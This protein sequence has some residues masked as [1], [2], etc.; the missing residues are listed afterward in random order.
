MRK[1]PVFLSLVFFYISAHAQGPIQLIKYDSKACVKSEKVIKEK[2]AKCKNIDSAEHILKRE[3]GF[4]PGNMYVLFCRDCMTKDMI[5]K[6]SIGKLFP[7]IDKDNMHGLNSKGDNKINSLLQL[8][9]TVADSLSVFDSLQLD[10]FNMPPA[11]KNRA[12]T[13]F[14]KIQG[15]GQKYFPKY[16]KKNGLIIVKKE[17]FGDTISYQY[18]LNAFYLDNGEEKLIPGTFYLFFLNSSEKEEL[19]L[20]ARE[21]K[22]CDDTVFTDSTGIA[23]LENAICGKYKKVDRES[24]ALWMLKCKL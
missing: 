10:I 11:D 1:F 19:A 12:Q 24:L 2:I 6:S 15:G 9:E 14:F 3:C 16:D 20:I 21:L 4:T 23:Y 18:G 22:E 8:R 7:A 13:I 17:I 5:R